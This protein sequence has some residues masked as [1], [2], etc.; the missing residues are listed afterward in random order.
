MDKPA[1]ERQ[2]IL[3][4]MKQEKMEWQWHQLDNMQIMCTSL[5]T[6]NHA[7]SRVLNFLQT[8]CPTNSVKAPTA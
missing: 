5:Q 2:G 7:S 6:D 3:D 1:A 4:F 8:G